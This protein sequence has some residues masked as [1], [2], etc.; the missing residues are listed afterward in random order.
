MKRALWN[1]EFA[2]GHWDCLENTTDDIIYQYLV[3]YCKNG[4]LLDLGC[5]SGNTGCELEESAY[6]DYT[7]VDISDVA[8]Q[9]AHTR[10]DVT[11][12][13]RK[14]RYFQGDITTYTPDRTYDVIL[15][16]ESIPYIPKSAIRRQLERYAHYLKDDGVFIIRWFHQAEGQAL[17]S[18]AVDDYALL[19]QHKAD[20][21]GP[22]IVVMQRHRTGKST[23]SSA[24]LL[25]R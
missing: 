21:V 20:G 15:F 22:F 6:H 18:G 24:P 3:K 4:S 7:G 11:G 10:C 23:S 9:R 13:I 16:R 8:I 2:T 14:N 25:P 1:K 12:R 19:E 5:G 17:L